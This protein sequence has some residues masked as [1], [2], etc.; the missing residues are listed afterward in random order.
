MVL[1]SVTGP[2][3]ASTSVCSRL[4]PGKFDCSRQRDLGF[5]HLTSAPGLGT[6]CEPGA[7]TIPI[8]TKGR[9]M[10]F[11]VWLVLFRHETTNVCFYMLFLEMTQLGCSSIPHGCWVFTERCN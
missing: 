8:M 7:C 10:L 4:L 5:R 6:T 1:R 3:V 11:L 9:A 2:R